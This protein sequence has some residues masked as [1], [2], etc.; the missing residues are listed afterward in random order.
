MSGPLFPFDVKCPRCS[1]RHFV[2]DSGDSGV[3]WSLA[4]GEAS[5]GDAFS[6]LG[7]PVMVIDDDFSGRDRMAG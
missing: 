7:L 1:T 3:P 4:E 6:P 5:R 2:T